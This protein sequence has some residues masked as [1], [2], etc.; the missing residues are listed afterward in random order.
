MIFVKQDYIFHL[1]FLSLHPKSYIVRE[2]KEVAQDKEKTFPFTTSK[3]IFKK[4]LLSQ[5]YV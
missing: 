1:E 2:Q 4:D 3:V 5:S